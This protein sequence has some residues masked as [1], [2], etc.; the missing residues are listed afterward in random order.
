VDCTPLLARCNQ[1]NQVCYEA[2]VGCRRD[3][4]TCNEGITRCYTAKELCEQL[5]RDSAELEARA[6]EHHHQ[7][8]RHHIRAVSSHLRSVSYDRRSL[9]RH[10]GDIEPFGLNADP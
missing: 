10:A 3:Q 5:W 9:I 8:H 2:L 1:A 6:P 7:R 4:A